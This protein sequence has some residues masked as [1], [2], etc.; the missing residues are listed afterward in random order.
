MIALNHV[1]AGT[2]IGL[3]VRR[4]ELAAPV[5]FLSHF[6]LDASPHYI[7]GKFGT[8]RFVYTWIADAVLSAAA[9]A[10][11]ALAAPELAFATI[12]GG[13]FAELPDVFW[14]HYHMHGKPKH[15]F[16]ELHT[17]IQWSQT[18][19]GLFYELGYLVLLVALNIVLLAAR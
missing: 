6:V 3:A 17:K 5:A 12:V 1:L 18:E 8:K 2:A 4:P 14:V 16:Y 7:Y 19:R 10:A 11:I 9:L 15:W 13:V